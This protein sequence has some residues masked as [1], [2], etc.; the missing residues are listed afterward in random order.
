MT[1]VV[2]ASVAVAATVADG[3]DGDWARATLSSEHLL[4]P[5]LL[6]VEVANSL[7]RLVLA[8]R[9]AASAAQAALRDLHDLAIEHYPF[10]PFAERVWE[11][12]TTLTAYDA[13][14]VAVAEAHGAPLATLD[15]R[16]SRTVGPE[17][18]F[19]VPPR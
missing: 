17:C 13:W 16:L 9:V 2:D 4:A 10:E 11:L 15:V 7:R 8:G 6:P 12:R 5:H 18:A 1:L 3:E 19:A 14:Y